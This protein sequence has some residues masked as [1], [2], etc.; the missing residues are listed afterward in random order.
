MSFTLPIAVPLGRSVFF[1]LSVGL[2]AYFSFSSFISVF[3]C[4]YII[5]SSALSFT[6]SFLP[7]TIFLSPYLSS[8]LFFY[9]HSLNLSLCSALICFS[10][11]YHC[12]ALS[13]SRSLSL[14]PSLS[15]PLS[16][17]ISLPP[18]FHSY[19]F[20]VVLSLM[21]AFTLCPLRQG[22][23]IS[24]ISAVSQYYEKSS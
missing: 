13:L 20:L 24:C 14:S 17:F 6:L 21:L 9:C 10:V 12:I 8:C 19:T 23:C 1:S 16:L 7:V 4:L 3:F 15:L 18:F 11:Q 22:I 5:F 2:S